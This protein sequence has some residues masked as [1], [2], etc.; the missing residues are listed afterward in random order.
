MYSCPVP[1]L[2][3]TCAI[4]CLETFLVVMI[5]PGRSFPGVWRFGCALVDIVTLW[6]IDLCVTEH[7]TFVFHWMGSVRSRG[8]LYM[9]TTSLPSL[10]AG[11]HDYITSNTWLGPGPWVTLPVL[12][13]VGDKILCTPLEFQRNTLKT[14]VFMNFGRKFYFIPYILRTIYIVQDSL[15]NLSTL[16]KCSWYSS[17]IKSLILRDRSLYIFLIYS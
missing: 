7:W 1:T 14:A 10:V 11:L 6:I 4:L 8:L 16:L 2:A 17:L 5:R 13:T 3:F 12:L 15:R 9:L